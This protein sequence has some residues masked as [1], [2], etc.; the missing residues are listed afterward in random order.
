MYTLCA[1]LFS[2]KKYLGYYGCHDIEMA[3]FS[4]E[5][6]PVS[7]PTWTGFYIMVMEFQAIKWG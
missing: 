3:L 5:E 4:N 2:F 1:E 6:M 7:F